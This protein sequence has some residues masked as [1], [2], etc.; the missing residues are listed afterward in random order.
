MWFVRLWC[1]DHIWS[2]WREEGKETVERSDD[3]SWTLTSPHWCQRSLTAAGH[4]L[5]VQYTNIHASNVRF[6]HF[7][8]LID[9]LRY[10][11]KFCY[12]THGR[13]GRTQCNP[14]Q[15]SAKKFF[16]LWSLKLSLFVKTNMCKIVWRVYKAR[17]YNTIQ[18]T[19][20]KVP[21]IWTAACSTVLL[22]AKKIH[23]RQQN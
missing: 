10:R 19:A 3:L 5:K 8:G 7:W 4:S 12:L 17:H 2:L 11:Q 16:C 21:R 18:P 6:L 22:A 13:E 23:F 20:S 14:T 1:F 9:P 15:Q